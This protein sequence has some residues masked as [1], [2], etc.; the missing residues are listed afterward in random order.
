[1]SE[2]IFIMR[3]IKLISSSASLTEEIISHLKDEDSDYSSYLV[4]FPGKRPSH[5]LRK[6]ISFKRKKSF[7]PPR[8]FSMD[9][10]V[11]FLY[12]EKL[13]QG[14]KKL[15]SIDAVAILYKIHR[16]LTAPIGGEC[17]MSPED[18]LPLGMK[19]FH[20]LEELLIEDIPLH[21]VREIE[22]LSDEKVPFQTLKRVQSLTSFYENFYKEIEERHFSTRSLRYR[23]VSDRVD[24]LNLRDFKKIVIAGFFALTVS[25]KRLFEGLLKRDNTL[26]IFQDAKGIKERLSKDLGLE[27]K[28]NEMTNLPPPSDCIYFYQSPDT[29]GQVFGLAR[30]IKE[31]MEND[32]NFDENTVIV[33]PSSETLFP[34]LHHCLP[35]FDRDNY[36]VS[37][38][39]PLY[40]TPIYAFFNSIMEVVTSMEEGRLYVPDY[41][42]FIL[43]PYTKGIYFENRTDIT[44]IVFH[45][46]EEELTSLSTRKFIPFSAI[47][48]DQ[49]LLEKIMEKLSSSE[50]DI[51]KGE[52]SKHLKTIHENTI[53]KFFSIKDTGEFAVKSV[54]VLTYIYEE[55]TARLHPFFHPFVEAFLKYLHT[56]SISLFKEI[57]FDEPSGY[58]NFF[59]KYIMSCHIPFEGTPLHGVQ[60]LGFL[61]TRNLKFERVFFLDLNEG[62]VPELKIE[63]SLLPYKA[64]K[65]IG[66]PTY[67][68]REK[69]TS[70][71]FELLLKGAKE[72]YLFYVENDRKEKSRFIERL[73]WERQKKEKT[74]Q[75]GGYLKS[76]Q[77]SINLENKEPERVAKTEDIIAFLEGFTYSASSL[78]DYLLCPL[79][80]YYCYVLNLTKKRNLSNDVDKAEI[81]GFV[82]NV[83]A[84]FFRRRMGRVLS[85]NDLSIREMD[86]LVDRLFKESFGVE[87]T[88]ESYLLKRQIKARMVE[89]LER[90]Y[91]PLVRNEPIRVMNIEHSIMVR[92]DSFSLRG[93]LDRIERRGEK[94]YIVDYKIGG[95]D[96]YLKINYKRLN[97]EKRETWPESIGSLQLPF[98][99]LLYSEATGTDIAEMNASILL[100]GRARV[101]PEI[102][103]TLF[104]EEIDKG[105]TY[106]MLKEII[107]KL[108]KEIVDPQKPFSPTTNKKENCPFCAYQYICGTQ[109]IQMPRY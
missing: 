41:L 106:L 13:G 57:R 58:F 96:R 27:V 108:L 81:G 24:E 65:I 14:R 92:K 46:I 6:A 105:A 10:F 12:E 93:I 25:E 8:I 62:I 88:G 89:L 60:I 59:R 5:F 87:S 102:E 48:E 31:Q 44:R 90:Y 103:I 37:M 21:K 86:N 30:I 73:L 22:Y 47:D 28:D 71:Y 26:F 56:L 9:D 85:E 61:E 76:V 42:R 2:P 83:L 70:Y 84:H 33:L 97:P 43:H 101:G 64:R 66:L 98:Y 45:T 80:F 3:Q 35:L 79:K 104:E 77:Y 74:L 34:L 23:T 107:F 94:T 38:G 11:D 52:V 49:E 55:S 39:Y 63:D 15:D 54:D 109:W 7:I 36:N 53:G 16:E 91:I 19:I 67:H 78:N 50:I 17:F 20:D 18:F 82:H 72:V 99:L 4:V 75:A 32:T 100:L 40:R 29:H 1:M 69:L 51:E 95:S 68:D